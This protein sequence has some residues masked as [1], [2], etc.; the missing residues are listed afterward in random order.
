MTAPTISALR[1]ARD[2]VR[3]ADLVELRLDAVADPDVDGALA[4]RRLPVIVTCRPRWEGGSFQGSEEERQRVLA[5]ALNAGAEYIDVEWRAGFNDLV[6]SSG[7][8]RIVLSSHNFSETPRDLADQVRAMRATGAEI[9]KIATRANR[10]SDCLQLRRIA[11]SDDP[12]RRAVWIA[13]GDAGLATR[14]LAGHFCSAWTYAG[15]LHE[16][17]QITAESLLRDFRFR[18]IRPSTEIYG[19]LGS[20]IGHSVSPAMHNAAFAETDYDAVYLPLPAADVDDFVTF[21]EGIGLKGASVTI[22]YKVPLFERISDV[23]DT[24]RRIGALNTVR[25][26]SGN[27]S[28]RNTDAAGFLQPLDEHGVALEGRR[29]SILGAGGSARAVAVAAASRKAIVTVHARDRERAAR[30]AAL[31]GGRIGEFPAAMGSW[32]LLV[33]CTPVGMHPNTE[34]T[35]VPRSMLNAG[36]VYDLVY[37]P[38][39][40][41]LLRDAEAE[42]CQTIGGLDMLVGQAMEQ[43]YWWTGLQPPRAVMR[44]AALK[45]LA[46][47]QQQ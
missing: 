47:F 46:E 26:A 24:S 3:D 40:T 19:L 6:A 37:N 22:P 14:V 43:F 35:P 33:N 7:G 28:G 12:R 20:P 45:R 36:F 21:A 16:I 42:G 27:W 32:D 11:S 13:M 34:Q 38:S 15:H 29:V 10:L 41:C 4:G 18:S 2:A 1:E 23:D 8:R 39:R 44:A 30:V 31:A 25:I 17:G 9:V 5:T